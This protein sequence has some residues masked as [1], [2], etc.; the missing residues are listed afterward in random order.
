MKTYILGAI[1]IVLAL[2]VVSL[3]VVQ[4][5]YIPAIVL[6]TSVPGDAMKAPAEVIKRSPTSI[7]PTVAHTESP[8]ERLMPA[9]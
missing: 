7:S 8:D 2:I 4:I 3:F 9:A 1:A 5:L 6:S